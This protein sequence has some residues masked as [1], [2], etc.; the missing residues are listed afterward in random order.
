MPQRLRTDEAAGQVTISC[1]VSDI[2]V[3]WQLAETTDGTAVAVRVE[4]PEAEASSGRPG[5]GGD[6]PPAQ[7]S[8]IETV[9]AARPSG[10]SPHIA[11]IVR[12]S[13]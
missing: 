5:R 7:M 1:Q 6:Q 3:T 8:L 10:G 4:L 9:S 12:I 2:D 13:R 11:S